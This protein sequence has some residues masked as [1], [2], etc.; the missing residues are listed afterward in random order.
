MAKLLV[1][2]PA[3]DAD[4]IGEA[5][6]G[7]QWASRLA[8]RHEMTLLSWRKR[9][10]PRVSRHFPGERVIEWEA[11]PG[12]GRAER[13][14]ALFKPAYPVFYYRARRW[15]RAALAS[16]E[17]FDIAHQP[18][19]VAMRYPSPVAGLG[20]PF[21]VGP[22]GGG[23]EDPPAFKGEDTAPWYVGLRRLDR[24]RLSHDPL[25]RRTY[26]QASCV[27]GIA[28]Y[29]TDT[30]DGV[31]VRNLAYFSETGVD[32]RPPRFDRN[33]R[34]GTVR[35]LFVGRLIRT[36]GARDAIR[37]VAL[38]GDLDVE[39][40]IVGDGFDRS[41]CES[42]VSELALQ[43]RVKFLGR[44]PREQ[45]SQ[46]Y[47]RADIFVFPSY[48]EPGG[49][50][51]FE[52]MAASLPL[53]VADRGGPGYVVDDR[54]GIRVEPIT[55]QQFARDLARAI[56]ELVNNPDRRRAMGAAAYERVGEVGDW[57]V[58]LDLIDA[59]YTEA[60]TGA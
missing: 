19:P 26:E 49:N 43:D 8:Q 45:V 13:F 21:I 58:K 11:P 18:T 28:P 44:Q 2:A 32:T 22:V 46:A 17:H 35:L 40:E 6:V 39:L 29:I 48:R 55:P 5:W 10:Q 57:G 1:I 54:C 53:I 52:A 60:L 50:V 41:A 36:K 33:D 56:R 38:L 12:L 24:W 31:K 23:L 51:T 20:I 16:G 30:L 42:L 25:L 14:D 4:D 37:A 47:E 34:S 15:I 3:C 7:Y 27:I 9:G 59:I